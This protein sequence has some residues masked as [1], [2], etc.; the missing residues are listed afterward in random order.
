M[1]VPGVTV[2]SVRDRDRDRVRDRPGEQ[3][4]ELQRPLCCDVIMMRAVLPK[5]CSDNFL[6]TSLKQEDYNPTSL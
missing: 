6:F 3:Q 2:S 5:L 4:S 1:T